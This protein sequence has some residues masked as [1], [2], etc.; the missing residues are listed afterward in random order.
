MQEDIQ[1]EAFHKFPIKVDFIG[2]DDAQNQIDR[3]KHQNLTIW[4]AQIK[5]VLNPAGQSK[6]SWTLEE[7]GRLRSALPVKAQDAVD[8]A[9]KDINEKAEQYTTKSKSVDFS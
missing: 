1:S 5:N 3:T 2:R 9:I 7:I 8:S 6:R 4:Q